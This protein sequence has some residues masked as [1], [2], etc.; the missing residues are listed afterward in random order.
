MSLRLDDPRR[1]GGRVRERRGSNIL[2]LRRGNSRATCVD[3]RQRQIIGQSGADYARVTGSNILSNNAFSDQSKWPL[4]GRSQGRA[5]GQTARPIAKPA[6]N[7]SVQ[8]TVA[9]QPRPHSVRKRDDEWKTDPA[10]AAYCRDTGAMWEARRPGTSPSVGGGR[11]R[12]VVPRSSAAS[13]AAARRPGG[14]RPASG[15]RPARRALGD[16]ARRPDA[17]DARGGP[18]EYG[19]RA[20]C[21]GRAE[22]GSPQAAQ[23][24]GTLLPSLVRPNARATGRRCR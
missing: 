21:G 11:R 4:P 15:V 16:D 20:A 9:N 3:S 1:N 17:R 6:G 2:T 23:P 10:E 22:G 14:A 5:T 12:N 24:M 8:V 13:S 18:K 19:G 7:R